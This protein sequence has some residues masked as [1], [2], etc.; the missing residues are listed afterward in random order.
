MSQRPEHPWNNASHDGWLEAESAAEP[1]SLTALAKSLT[2]TPGA[3]TLGVLAITGAGIAALAAPLATG[4]HS[5]QLSD[6][7]LT[8]S[9]QNKAPA[10]GEASGPPTAAPAPAPGSDTARLAP[11][12][13][14]TPEAR[15]AVE[16]QRTPGESTP[17]VHQETPGPRLAPA[18]SVRKPNLSPVI[19]AGAFGEPAEQDRSTRRS[20]ASTVDHHDD[21]ASSARHAHRRSG[22]SNLNVS[23]PTARKDKQGAP[24]TRAGKSGK[25]GSSPVAE[26]ST[27]NS[28]QRAVQLRRGDTLSRLAARYDTTVKALQDLNELGN[29]T[30]IYAGSTLIVPTAPQSQDTEAIPPADRQD[31]TERS[32]VSPSKVVNPISANYRITARFGAHGHRW[33]SRH[34]GLDL[35]APTGTAIRAVSNGR[36]VSTGWNKYYGWRTILRHEDG[37]QSWYCHQSSFEKRTGYVEAGEVIGRVGATGNAS[38]PHLHLEI[39]QNGSP[40]N[41]A[42]WLRDHGVQV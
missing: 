15:T 19:G 6:Q 9:G 26:A 20:P 40:V 18:Y 2:A 31:A 5:P 21:D 14:L 17:Q 27:P 3:R 35:A 8:A 24:G 30:R 38:G 37:V 22:Q 41:P 39:R 10:G 28:G 25:D 16:E 29:S 32:R 33:S 4:Q 11:P 36:I 12:A 42:T 1:E 34:T 23:T 13:P 7:E